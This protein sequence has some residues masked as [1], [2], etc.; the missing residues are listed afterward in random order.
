M[1]QEDLLK[2]IEPRYWS[3]RKMYAI[4][5]LR[6]GILLYYSREFIQYLKLFDE[7]R[8]GSQLKVDPIFTVCLLLL[9][10]LL[11]FP[12]I[13]NVAQTVREIK[14]DSS[15]FRKFKIRW[16]SV[17]IMFLLSVSASL[18]FVFGGEW[19]YLF[20]SYSPTFLK[21]LLIVALIIVAISDI[22]IEKI[23]RDYEQ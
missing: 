3:A 8:L 22:N 5:A 21:P 6:I 1:Q 7:V 20:S 2:D 23:A 18:S 16:T 10:S 17:I 9:F 11:L 4:G 12:I 13:Y 14:L 19:R 15:A